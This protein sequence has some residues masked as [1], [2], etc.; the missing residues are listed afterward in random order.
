MTHDA[1]ITPLFWE[2]VEGTGER[3]MAAALIKMADGV[4]SHLLLR[5][6]VL[7]VMYGSAAAA[8]KTMF[9]SA[10][11]AYWQM[12]QANVPIT[13]KLFGMHPGNTIHTDVSSRNEAVK[14][15]ALMFSSLA[16]LDKIDEEEAEPL[17]SEVSKRFMTSVRERVLQTAPQLERYFNRLSP[18]LDDSDEVRFG[19]ISE[20]VM[21]HFSV[22]SPARPGA[23]LRDARAKLW[24]L[25]RGQAHTRIPTAGI[26]I[27]VPHDDD[28]T[29]GSKQQTQL[30]ASLSSLE[31]EADKV[32]LLQW[33]ARSID[34]AAS[35]VCQ[36]A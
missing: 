33:P 1:A 17:P 14:V 29:L 19:F 36:M 26:L 22:Y 28:P 8:L 24:E 25:E 18:L 30:R 3:L 21:I 27:A 2:P 6:D 5:D 9:E 11:Q 4:S 16:N 7:D 12:A 15:A 10:L 20:R 31:R 34:E 23:S 35:R 32:N 13:A